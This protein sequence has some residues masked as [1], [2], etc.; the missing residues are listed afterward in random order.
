MKGRFVTGVVLATVLV[1]GAASAGTTILARATEFTP[2]PLRTD[3]LSDYSETA[4]V[5]RVSDN[6][7]RV[8]GLAVV[9]ARGTPREMGRQYGRA[10]AQEIKHGIKAYLLGQVVEKWGYPLGYQRLCAQAMLRHIPDEYIEE[11]KGVAEGAGVDYEDVLLMHTH[12]D[13]VHYGKSWGRP[14]SAPGKECSNFAVWGRWTTHGQLIHGRNLDWT[15]S[16]G[17]QSVACVYVGLPEQGVPFALVTHAGLIGAVTGMNAEGITFGEMTSSS[18]RE[19]LDGMPLMLICRKIL[20]YCRTMDEA[21]E[22]VKGYPRTTGWNFLIA[23]GKVPTARAFEVDAEQVVVF[24][25]GDP[26]ENDPPIHWPMPD[27]VRRTN[28]FVSRQ[29]Q[30]KQAERA[31]VPYKLGRLAIRGIDTWH[32]YAA[33]SHWIKTH[34]GQID[35]RLARALLQTAPVG[36]NGNLHSVVMEPARRMMWVANASWQDGHAEPAWSQH[37]VPVDLSRFWP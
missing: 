13:M 31:G 37:Y 28:H 10:L 3:L 35:A 24:G 30:V 15:T 14:D 21:V 8:D 6:L 20:Q 11:M 18:S 17:V 9:V 7:W 5:D 32:R 29:M 22:M 26:K 34:E 19:T 4:R 25:P 12:A 16:T 23:D 27:C 1:L 36:G 33:L 2:P